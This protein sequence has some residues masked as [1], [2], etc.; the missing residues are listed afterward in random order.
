M[1]SAVNPE[2]V[3]LH[4]SHDDAGKRVVPAFEAYLLSS[5]RNRTGLSHDGNWKIL[6]RRDTAPVLSHI[7]KR[8]V[9]MTPL[10]SHIPVHQVNAKINLSLG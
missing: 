9:C 4:A 1:P 6:H 7:D 10:Q 2:E 8:F 3:P 5:I